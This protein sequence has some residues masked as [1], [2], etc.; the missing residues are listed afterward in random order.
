MTKFTLLAVL[1]ITGCAGTLRHKS[2][3]WVD[4]IFSEMT[5][6]QKVGHMMAISYVPRFLNQNNPQFLG[7]VKLVRDYHIGGIMFYK[8]M[9]YEVARSIQRLQTE[10]EVPLLVMADIEWGLAMRVNQATDFLQNMAIGATGS[11]EFAYEMGKITAMEARAMG[12]HIGYAPVM[13]VNNNPDNLIINTRSYSEN[14]GQV[15]LLGAAFIRGMQ[16]QGVFATAKH[17]PGHGDTDVD[18]HLNLPVVTA[19]KERIQ[20]TEL[21]PFQ[22]AVAA[23]VKA[24]MVGHINFSAYRQ[25]QGRPAT[26]DSYFIQEVLRKE[27]GFKG[28]VFTDAMDMGGITENYWSGEAA[29]MAIN[30]GV[31]MVLIPPNFESTFRFVVKAVRDG[32]IP[33]HR[34]DQAVKRILQAKLELGL[35]KKPAFDIQELEAVLAK[36][37]FL[38]KSEEIAN[39]AMTLLRDRKNALPFHAEELDSVLVVTITDEENRAQRGAP[40]N[41]EVA[42]RI[43]VVRTAYVDPRTTQEELLG[44]L[45]KCDSSQAVIVGAFVNWG[46]YKGSVTLPDTTAKLLAALFK[47]EK[48]MVVISFGS[49]YVLR[50]IADAPSYLCAYGT[51]PLAVRAAIR[52][53]FGEIPLTAKLP[54]T[55]PGFHKIGDGL[56]KPAR[57]MELVKEIDDEFLRDAYA[58]LEQAIADSIFPGAQ[59]AVV[60][61]GALIASRG[62]GR[63]TYDPASPEIDTETIYDL[64]SVTK[65]AATTVCAMRLWEKKQLLLDVPVKSY[66]PKFKGGEKDSVTLRHLLTHSSGAHWWADLW[67]KADNKT[68]ALDYIYDLPLDYTPG[69]SMIYS[70]LGLIMIGEILETVTGKRIDSLSSA[71]IYKPMAMENTLFN[72]PKAL[73]PRIAPTEIGGSMNRGLIHG[74]VHD[75][76]T[77]FFSGISTHAGLFSTA[78]DLAALAQ[79]LLNGGIYRRR[80]FFTPNTVKYWTT[81]QNLPVG[82][83]RALGWRTPE[84]EGSSAGDLFS[85]GSFGHTGFTGTSIWIDPNRKIAIILL[86]NRVHPTRERGGMYPVRRDFH[87]A[88]MK[89]MLEKQEIPNSN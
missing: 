50:Q 25:M 83:A 3:N 71:L 17:F 57:K 16:E 7:L 73:L 48:P 79:M 53:I 18:S 23:G 12:V 44:T 60:R 86:S 42:K 78:E 67:N 40:L 61:D 89:A 46:S 74:E 11:E 51:K 77:Y 29:V 9:P 28:L 45:A 43:P 32:R 80:R 64:A 37:E 63:Q 39:A 19:S 13:D 41:R 72:P 85:E 70:D 62:F 56:Q 1:L 5:I 82:S 38:Q 55:I 52:A 8:G 68:E 30:A 36:P 15:A 65:V 34:I 24:V 27:M 31:D 6:E 88:A 49:P 4:E 26:L 87:N 2:S 81:R 35:N 14:P 21:L 20:K 22:A 54:V 10:T 33:M 69:D 76:N 75:E 59:V 84:N 66:L 47:I 58:V